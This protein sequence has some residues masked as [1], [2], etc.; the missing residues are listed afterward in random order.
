MYDATL[1]DEALIDEMYEAAREEQSSKRK[2]VEDDL[3]G[4]EANRP[5]RRGYSREVEAI[6]DLVDNVVALRGEM[7]KWPR[8]ATERSMS[9]RPWFPSEVVQERMRQYARKRRDAA[10]KEAQDR[11]RKANGTYDGS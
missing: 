2:R 7:G 10:I 8:T 6:Y 5:P 1:G 4:L 3:A 11:W 9:K